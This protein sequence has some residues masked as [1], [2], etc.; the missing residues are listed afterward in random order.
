MLDLW[1][2]HQISGLPIVGFPY[3]EVVLRDVDRDASDCQGRYNFPYCFRY[4]MKVWRDLANHS[5]PQATERGAHPQDKARGKAPMTSDF[6]ER[7][8]TDDQDIYRHSGEVSLDSWVKYFYNRPFCYNGTFTN[9]S[10]PQESMTVISPPHSAECDHV[11]WGNTECP[12]PCDL[13]PVTHLTTYLSYWLATF[14]LPYGHTRLLWL[15]VI[16]P[17]CCLACRV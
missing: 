9:P 15:D 16:Y 17:A 11:G 12:N 8:D 5:S 13:D 10:H 4:L 14:A 2:F 6:N 1:T 7:R 3:E